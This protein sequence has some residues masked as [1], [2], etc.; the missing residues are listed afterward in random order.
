MF[1]RQINNKTDRDVEINH[2]SVYKHVNTPP[3]FG[4]KDS[5]S[6]VKAE[7]SNDTEDKRVKKELRHFFKKK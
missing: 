1:L 2:A 6:F 5:S 3:S 7:S 4:N